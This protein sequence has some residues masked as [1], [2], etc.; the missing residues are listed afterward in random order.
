MDEHKGF[1]D[2]RTDWQFVTRGDKGLIYPGRGTYIPSNR[3][4]GNALNAAIQAVKTFE[5]KNESKSDKRR[6]PNT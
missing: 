3:A 4:K 2:D 1:I 6:I 5:D